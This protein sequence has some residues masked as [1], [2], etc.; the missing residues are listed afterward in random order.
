MNET[1]VDRPSGDALTSAAADERPAPLSFDHTIRLAGRPY[2]RCVKCDYNLHGLPKR[3]ACPECGLAFD[4][5]SAVYRNEHP[6][7]FGLIVSGGILL[8][9]V[10]ALWWANGRPPNT[11]FVLTLSVVFTVQLVLYL[12]HVTGR[13]RQEDVVA[14][15]A[16]GLMLKL[17]QHTNRFVHWHDIQRVRLVR[18]GPM[19]FV[20]LIIRGRGTVRLHAVPRGTRDKQFLVQ[21]IER[22]MKQAKSQSE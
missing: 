5:D 21:R 13:R 2:D 19:R 20:D 12:L 14:V 7:P 22:G 1:K 4:E 17:E 11:W 8:F 10:V 16:D 18:R 6:F 15:V 9:N 3:G